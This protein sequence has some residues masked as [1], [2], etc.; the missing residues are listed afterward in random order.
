[1]PSDVAMTGELTLTGKVL[2]IGGVKE[3]IIAAK[4]SGARR[5]IFPKANEGDY[6][7]L[8]DF[9][10]DGIDT[11]FVASFDELAKIVFGASNTVGR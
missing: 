3:K 2:R 4:R 1:M 10:K 9:I 11:H 6:E 8:E 5:I 7:D